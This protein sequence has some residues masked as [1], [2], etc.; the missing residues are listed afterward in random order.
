MTAPWVIGLVL[1][2]I[3]AGIIFL[4]N[5][6]PHISVKSIGW[7]SL[8]YITIQTPKQRITIHKL[9]ITFRLFNSTVKPFHI[10]LSDVEVRIL[11]TANDRLTKK[12]GAPINLVNKLVGPLSFS[13]PKWLYDGIMNLGIINS[14]QIHFFRL[15]VIHERIDKSIHLFL[16]YTRIEPCRHTEI[17]KLTFMTLNG[18][19][20]DHDDP[21]T[22]VRIFRS[23]E[24]TIEFNIVAFCSIKTPNKMQLTFDGFQVKMTLG[25][26]NL[27]LELFGLK[28]RMQNFMREKVQARENAST[29]PVVEKEKKP[30]R[31]DILDT[32]LELCRL[33]DFKLEDLTL[34][35]GNFNVEVNNF[36]LSFSKEQS[37][38]FQKMVSKLDMYMSSLILS[39]KNYKCLEL[40][41]SSF[42]SEADVHGLVDSL[43]NLSDSNIAK[44]IESYFI[45]TFTRPKINI[46]HDQIEGIMSLTGTTPKSKQPQNQLQLQWK[47]QFM[48][49][50]H[51]FSVKLV[52]V[53]FLLVYHSLKPDAE[54]NSHFKRSSK[55][56]FIST[57][58]ILSIIHKTYTRVYRDF[59]KPSKME[60]N[61]IHSMVLVKNLRFNA[62]GNSV[63]FPKLSTV[64]NFD[65]ERNELTMKF[66]SKALKMKSV[67]SAVFH[68]VRELG[69]RRIVNYNNKYK[70]LYSDETMVPKTCLEE[71]Y[72]NYVPYVEL[73]KL[74]PPV[75]KRIK[76]TIS[77]IQAD[78]ICK[79]GLP[80]HVIHEEKTN[81]EIDLGDFKRGVCLRLDEF[82]FTYK[83]AKEVFDIKA[84]Q[85][86]CFTLSEYFNEYVTD[87]DEVEEYKES[88]SEFSDISS[89]NSSESIT[90]DANEDGTGCK[91]IKRVLSLRDLRLSN[92]QRDSEDINK[93][94]L[95]IP[96]ID[97]RIDLFFV[98]CAFYAKT[99]VKS[100]APT[101]KRKISKDDVNKVVGPKRVV[102]LDVLVESAALVTRIPNGADVL[103][104]IDSLK[105]R[106][107]IV[108][109]TCVLKNA[110]L[111]V[112]Q[113]ATKMWSRFITIKDPT[114]NVNLTHK[115][116]TSTFKVVT[117]AIRFN[118]PYMFAV[119]TVID[120][121]ITFFKA[122]KQIKHNFNNLS[123][124]IED[125]SRILPQAKETLQLPYIEVK[126]TTLGITLENDPF[127]IELSYIFEL[128]AIEQ[129][130]RIMKLKL[131]EKRAAE[132]LS[133]VE[134][135]DEEKIELTEDLPTKGKGKFLKH[136]L[137]T[138]FRT[139]SNHHKHKR[140]LFKNKENIAIGDVYDKLPETP[141]NNIEVEISK[142][143]D[144]LNEHL[145]NSW[146]QKFKLF[147]QVKNKNW[148]DRKIRTWGDDKINKLVVDKYDILDY[149]EGAHLF[150]AVFR[151]VDLI[152]DK[153]KIPNVDDFLYTYAQKQP[154]FIYSILLPIFIDLRAQSFT[155][156][157]KDYPL[158][159]AYF[160]SNA[161]SN[162]KAVHLHG[163]FVVNE[164][165]VTRQEEMRH[166]FVPFS[167]AAPR[168]SLSDVFYSVFIPRTL[169][170]VKFTTDLKLDLVSERPCILSWC[171]SYLPA[172]LSVASALDNF[173]KPPVDDS[174]LGWWDKFSLMLHGKLETR[175]KN[176]LCLHIKSSTNP[177]ALM[178]DAAGFVFCWKDDVSL[179]VND[180]GN[181]EELLQL[182]SNGFVLA[183]PNYSIQDKKLWSSFFDEVEDP[184]IYLDES[185]RFHKKIVKLSSANRV[186]WTF[187]MIF[188]RNK[189]ETIPASPDKE[190]VSTFQ[191]HY[192]VDIMNPAFPNHPD[193][194]K[195]FRS[196][197]IHMAFTVKSTS[198]SGDCFNA[199]YF[200]PYTF[201]YF[202][203]WWHSIHGGISLP[204]KGGN[205]FS[206]KDPIKQKSHIN[207]GKHIVT[208]K[209]LFQFD[210]LMISH[211]YMH[212]STVDDESRVAFTGLKARFSKCTIDLHQRKQLL[213]Y[214]NEYL[215][216][217]NK[218]PH[219]KMHRGEI[220]TENAEF[221][222][223][224]AIF[225]DRSVRG[226]LLAAMAG[227]NKRKNPG[228]APPPE[229]IN[230]FDEW[231][232]A[233]EVS[234]ND[235]SWVDAEDFIELEVKE[236][237]SPY[238]KIRI[239]SFCTSPKFS[240]F[241]EFEDDDQGRFPFGYESSHDCTIGIENPENTQATLLSNRIR[242]IK[243]DIT[244]VKEKLLEEP[245]AAPSK[246]KG[247][248]YELGLLQEKLDVVESIW[249]SFTGEPILGASSFTSRGEESGLLRPKTRTLSVYSSHISDEQIRI[250]NQIDPTATKFRNRFIVHNL[251][252]KWNNQ[253]KQFFT[254][255]LQKVNDRKSSVYF[256]SKQAIDFV[257]NTIKQNIKPPLKVDLEDIVFNQDIKR[258]DDVVD[259]F[260]DRIDERDTDQ[261]EVE[262]RY[263]I[264]FI[265]PQIQLVSDEEPDACVIVTSRDLQMRVVSIRM[266]GSLQTIN[267]SLEM[268]GLIEKRYGV[269]F[270]DYQV[271][272]FK[273][274]DL[275]L[276]PMYYSNV[277]A[278]DS[279]TW[280]PWLENEA[281]YE[282]SGVHKQLVVEKNSMGLIYKNP[283]PLHS[284][285]DSGPKCNALTVQLAKIV[286][287]AS[288]SQ[289]STLF[290]VVTGLLLNPKTQR[291]E[292]YNRLD[293]LIA[294]TDVSDFNGLDTKVVD[295]QGKIR[296]Y[297]E[298][299]LKMNQV[300][301]NP[302]EKLQ[303]SQLEFELEKNQLELSALLNALRI[304]S[305]RYKAEK[306]NHMVWNIVS[307][308][309]IWHLLD[310]NRD[311]FI[312]FALYNPT[313]RKIDSFDGSNSNRIVVELIQGFNLQKSSVYPELLQ[314]YEVDELTK[315]KPTITFSW[316][317]M[318][319]VGG[320]PILQSAKL[321]IQPLAI[322]FDY[323][324]AKTL[325]SYLFPKSEKDDGTKQVNG[326]VVNA[327]QTE[328]N[329]SASTSTVDLVSTKSERSIGKT[330]SSPFRSLMKKRLE[331]RESSNNNNGDESP[332]SSI[333]SLS[334]SASVAISG[335]GEK[336]S[337]PSSFSKITKRSTSR[338]KS[339]ENGG[340][341]Q[342]DISIIVDR[343][344]KFMSIVDMDISNFSLMVSFRAPPHLKILDVHKLNLK[345]PNLRYKDKLWS[346]EDVV[347][348]IRKD[349]LRVIIQHSGKIIGNKFKVRNRKKGQAASPLNQIS[350]FSSYL[351]V[352]DLQ[353]EG[354]A[355][356]YLKD[357]ANRPHA[358]PHSHHHH[359]HHHHHAGTDYQTRTD[360]EH[361]L[362]EII[363]EENED[364]STNTE[365]DST[366]KG[367]SA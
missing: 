15:S 38:K 5:L 325:F 307:D 116:E 334:D 40:P 71:E 223:V 367:I 258:G 243:R 2:V 197:Y 251:Q 54:P 266:M 47:Q 6:I 109:K 30:F 153:A 288:S 80:L 7:L 267:E 328:L 203:S 324:T 311:P 79:D 204:I 92:C 260:S 358:T 356:D 257:E 276:I 195:T 365:G 170:T 146:V 61:Q 332:S 250:A 52:I 340:N 56:N 160:P 75:V 298:I 303:F 53:D 196:S 214:V 213:T 211:M 24:F 180:T 238:P 144:I 306:S 316:S 322:Q 188:E 28:N 165:L 283:N 192:E 353:K 294:L 161:N 3:Y 205:L 245:T 73:F 221:K 270:E 110:R 176:E 23:I 333:V 357:F 121:I 206:Q 44:S 348:N 72:T 106:N 327:P 284:S 65:V 299:F 70:Y 59:D 137:L 83:L 141:S 237:L 33:I 331:R 124:N 120:N 235:Y 42:T 85:F 114:V 129:R 12:K 252:L 41:S 115:I 182:D 338:N 102:K 101:V 4:L 136:P 103:F 263:L 341:G 290:Y 230:T 98:W 285:E 173:S 82:D 198:G 200:T 217:C 125:Y 78:I 275:P 254:Q 159:L 352:Q 336:S 140:P 63:H 240:Y 143:K 337:P 62:L 342:D 150:G 361:I 300:E 280:P 112:V 142:A 343:S 1:L 248:E 351:T 315:K 279:K 224:N 318:N 49:K 264:K 118:V 346:T 291:D 363:D 232:A 194:Y 323:A 104:E 302:F 108:S 148:K 31:F 320:I 89:V 174:P 236:Q 172:I 35:W 281:C 18:W 149:P 29:V 86:Q 45:L 99:L 66:Q 57:F 184:D 269:L 308:Q 345:I 119:Y 220:N 362:Q 88:D 228:A 297:K 253:I 209:Y 212:P 122:I 262:N 268:E 350:D 272:V 133:Q 239:A 226:Q 27:S 189:D 231:I 355:R 242:R 169:Q 51:A 134:P 287:N 207:M 349:I 166:I 158:P 14:F 68:L 177:Y 274:N 359:H 91:R 167:P 152:L 187:G 344:S 81:K 139:D 293:K 222:I 164:R 26:V 256:M 16:E 181:S 347:L 216:T 179:K 282:F 296:M 183:I 64:V 96:E 111:Y 319:P 201:L 265:H 210:P 354:R 305:L 364:E 244:A 55:D 155:S 366:T 37:L 312:D 154:K 25:Q 178:G 76:F 147:R 261:E 50:L 233:S 95:V 259:E 335:D 234:E 126:T 227:I 100:F 309:V 90:R 208:V 13:M 123:P 278:D 43:I 138:I 151:Q 175:V 273:Q 202:F 225:N 107:I 190:R 58:T 295:L 218:V 67:N 17:S 171:K 255:Y 145:S 48:Q 292:L 321:D 135:T 74:I 289:Y 97:G 157:L 229:N 10:E 191:P 339:I 8:K 105:F 69:N 304:K 117:K 360:F 156:F 128:G 19:I 219:L 77:S 163:N 326:S 131:F 22:E 313:F 39:E 34:Q 186:C 241:R 94:N 84:K 168:G 329:S 249:E 310:N 46:Y 246:R 271:F 277:N 20:R 301:L 247:Y 314:P 317:T 215:N 286:V 185:K 127:E 11:D 132:W 113:P 130:E 87:F 21:A 93:L 162:V 32:V 193:S 36:S 60:R 9:K 199:G 330:L